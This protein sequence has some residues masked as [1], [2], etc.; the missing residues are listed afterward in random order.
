MYA[1]TVLTCTGCQVGS[2]VDTADVVTNGGAVLHG[3]DP[4]NGGGVFSSESSWL[5]VESLDAGLVAP[6]YVR[7]T[8]DYA[9]Y[10][11]TPAM[12]PSW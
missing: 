8:W 5:R 4:N 3:V 12:Y 11:D 9:A 7:N 10:D 1:C 6:G 2:E